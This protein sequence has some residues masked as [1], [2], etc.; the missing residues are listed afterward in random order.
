[1]GLIKVKNTISPPLKTILKRLRYN[2]NTTILPDYFGAEILPPSAA[3]H[4]IAPLFREDYF[5]SK[6][7]SPQ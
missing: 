2:G 6:T 4:S 3:E 7:V 5:L 1:V